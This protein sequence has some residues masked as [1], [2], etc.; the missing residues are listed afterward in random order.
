MSELVSGD[1]GCRVE[2]SQVGIQISREWLD[3]SRQRKRV[4]GGTRK[5]GPRTDLTP[6]FRDAVTTRAMHL[7]LESHQLRETVAIVNEEFGG[8]LALE[9]NRQGR[10]DRIKPEL[11][12][13]GDA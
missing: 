3:M 1:A 8:S 6:E 5:P 9:T 12:K 7:R 11:A 10:E 2:S 4:A 13:T